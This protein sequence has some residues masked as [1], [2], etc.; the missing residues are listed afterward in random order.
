MRSTLTSGFSAKRPATTQP[1]VPPLC[2]SGKHGTD[3]PNVHTENIPANNVV[4]GICGHNDWTMAGRKQKKQCV[5][6]FFFPVAKAPAS[7][8]IYSIPGA[9]RTTLPMHGAPLNLLGLKHNVLPRC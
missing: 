3:Q 7:L 6:F 1:E 8:G 4:K 9:S 2:M 5:T